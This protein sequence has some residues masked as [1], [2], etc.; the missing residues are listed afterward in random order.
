MKIVYCA[1]L[2][3]VAI[4]PA[5]HNCKRRYYWQVKM[6]NI[7]FTVQSMW[8]IF[9]F[10]FV[11][12][13]R[14]WTRGPSFFRFREQHTFRQP[15][16]N[17]TRL[18]GWSA[19]RRD[20]YLTTRTT[21]ATE[22]HLCPQQDSNPQSQQAS[23]FRSTSMYSY[24]SL[25]TNGYYMYH[26]FDINKLHMLPALCDKVLRMAEITME[27]ERSMFIPYTVRLLVLLINVL[28][29]FHKFPHYAFCPN[30]YHFIFPGPNISLNTLSP[31]YV[32]W[33]VH[34]FDS[35]I[36]VDRLDVTCFIISLFNAQHVSDVNTSILRSLRLIRWVIAWVVLLWYDVCWCY[37]VVWLAWCG[38]RMQASAKPQRNTNT[39]RTRAIQLMK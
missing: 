12:R 16:F 33:T 17:R 22:R 38:I 15:S 1:L 18:D 36:K 2:T 6:F 7:L 14:Y 21:V 23:S 9:F 3:A 11:A 13:Q 37:V 19:D 5:S 31:S 39:H 20:L 35:W 25:N 26:M 4:C 30:I 8:F 24:D 10:F 34:H 28:F 27:Y 32:Y 29:M